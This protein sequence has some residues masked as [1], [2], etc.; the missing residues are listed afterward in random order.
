[1]K[2]ILLEDVENVGHAGE[3]AEVKEGYFRNYLLPRRLAV[4]T[5]EGGLRFL[6]AK[7]K[8]AVLK[9]ERLKEQA[10]ALAAQLEKITCVIKARVGEEGKLFGS[11]TARDVHEELEKQGLVVERKRIEMAPIH[12]IGDYHAILKLHPEVEVTLKVSVTA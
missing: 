8:Q 3:T 12:K 10:K 6:E 2:V 7:K 1:M 9:S 5:T 4:P 11:V